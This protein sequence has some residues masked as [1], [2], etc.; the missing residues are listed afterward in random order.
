M[1][2]EAGLPQNRALRQVLGVWVKSTLFSFLF[3]CFGFVILNSAPQ[4][5]R[6]LPDPGDS[7]SARRTALPKSVVHLL[8]GLHHDLPHGDTQPEREGVSLEPL[9][10]AKLHPRR[11]PGPLLSLPFLSRLPWK[12]HSIGR[13]RGGYAL[14]LGG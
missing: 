10:V 1:S 8:R 7:G 6:G 12:N 3:S 4:T 14:G 5:F 2:L 13:C 9:V 11:I